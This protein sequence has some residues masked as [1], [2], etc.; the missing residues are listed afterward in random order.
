MGKA[1]KKA[2]KKADMSIREAWDAICELK[3]N[4]TEEKQHVLLAFCMGRSWKETM[5]KV[6]EKYTNKQTKQNTKTEYTKGELIQIHGYDEAM[7]Y[8]ARGKFMKVY[9]QDGDPF[10]IKSKKTFTSTAERSNETHLNRM[11]LIFFVFFFRCLV[12][13]P[14]FLLFRVKLFFAVCVFW[15]STAKKQNK[16]NKNTK[17]ET[18]QQQHIPKNKA[19]T[20]TTHKKPT[21]K[22]HKPK[23]KKQK[24]KAKTE[25]KNTCTVSV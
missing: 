1:L 16:Q 12:W 9:D 11:D 19:E 23:T 10:Y 6:S 15:N 14:F 18:N 22:T 13:P 20:N 5:I 4:Q 25:R 24:K 7:D 17:K 3:T 8:I 2:R 21:N